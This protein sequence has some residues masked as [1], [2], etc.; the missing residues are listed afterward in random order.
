[1]AIARYI[2]NDVDSAL[3]FYT[4]VLGFELKQRWGPPFASIERDDLEIWISGPGTSARAEM[5]DGSTPAPGGWNRI[6]IAV[7]DIEATVAELRRRDA[8]FR[9]EPLAGPAGTQVLVEDPSGNPIEL[10]QPA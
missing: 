6:V 5:P 7:E 3:E 2:V 4:Q 8:F 1:M 9:N 10:F